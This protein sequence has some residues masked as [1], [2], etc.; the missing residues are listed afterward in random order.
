MYSISNQI[1]LQIP[2]TIKKSQFF[3]CL[4]QVLVDFI[5]LYVQIANPDQ[6]SKGLSQLLIDY[7]R[8]VSKFT[9]ETNAFK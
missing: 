5:Y 7:T 3:L 2:C 9:A 8:Y 6:D 1:V 4:L